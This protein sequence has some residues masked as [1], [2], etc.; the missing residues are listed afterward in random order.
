MKMPADQIERIKELGYSESEARF[1]YIVAIHSGYF[2]LRRFRI[3]TQARRGKRSF[4]FSHK[5]LKRGHGSLRDY[6]GTGSVF[7]LFFRT[8]YGQMEK[9]NLR[10][11]KRHSFEFIRTRLIL[12]DFILANQALPYFETE[13]DKVSFFWETMGVSKDFRP[14]KVYEGR[15]GSQPTIRYF[16]DKFPLILALPPSGAPFVVTLSYVDSGF[17]APSSLL[18]HLRAYQALFRQ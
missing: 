12:L 7:H 18:T 5:L 14:S 4:V 15:P 8:I 9:D 1:L 11:H 10:N 6:M 17:Q 3:F 16:I 13:Q 2:T